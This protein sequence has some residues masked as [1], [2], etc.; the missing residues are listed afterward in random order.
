MKHAF[1]LGDK[2]E[3]GETPD[4]SAAVSAYSNI[5]NKRR[6]L[7]TRFAAHIRLFEPPISFGYHGV[8]EK[9]LC[10]LT[11]RSYFSNT[12]VSKRKRVFGSVN[13]FGVAV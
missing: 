6:C 10:T 1:A 7:F 4:G 2:R 12:P 8:L 3:Q 5:E 13:I 9:Y 11:K